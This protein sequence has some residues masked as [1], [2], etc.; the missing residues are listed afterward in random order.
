MRLRTT[1]AAVVVVGVAL[2]LGSLMLLET[3]RSALT[4]DVRT[5]TELRAR[6]LAA[7]L[8]AGE[9]P[10]LSVG[11]PD[12]GFIQVIDTTGSVVAS[13]DNVDGM[14][15]LVDLTPARSTVFEPPIGDDEFVA[16]AVSADR[17]DG[18]ATV[19]VGR[20]LDE[21]SDSTGA[22]AGLLSI[23]GP[24]LLLVVGITTWTVVGRALGPIEAI[25]AEVD[26]I[27]MAELHRRVPVPEAD[28]EVARLAG[29][30]NRMLTRL[31]DGRTRQRRFVADASHELRSPV[32]SMRQHAEVAAAHPDRTSL[33]GLAETVVAEAQRVQ[34]LV[35]DLLTLARVDEQRLETAM[36]PVDLDD[37]VFTEAVRRR[38]DGAVRID[39]SDVSAGR[40]AGDEAALRR[41]LRNLIDNAVRHAATTVALGLVETDEAVVVTVDD[42]GPGIRPADRDRIFERFVRLDEARTR[43]DGGAG[44]GLAIVTELV[45]VH[46]GTVD[47]DD[48]PLGGARFR[49]RFPAFDS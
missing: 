7:T 33:G 12:E 11:E 25:R 15:R 34:R 31:E 38:R 8:E 37:L 48:S 17:P 5:A 46:H 32:A 36:R 21:V 49:L 4:D 23:G 14:P 16:F 39:T 47:V 26:E 30:M 20:S 10:L 29:T 44:L 6:Q 9:T 22:V 13:S 40:V 28:D 43:D 27:S 41:V 42:D 3:L 18:A 24:L 2:V 1:G 19:I 45:A 35:D